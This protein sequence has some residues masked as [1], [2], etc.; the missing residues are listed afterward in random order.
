M[1]KM[2]AVLWS[3]SMYLPFYRGF[4]CS[5]SAAGASGLKNENTGHYVPVF[6]DPANGMWYLYSFIGSIE[7]ANRVATKAEPLLRKLL[8]NQI[9]AHHI[10]VH[11]LVDLPDPEPEEDFDEDIYKTTVHGCSRTRWPSLSRVHMRSFRATWVV[12]YWRTLRFRMVRSLALNNLIMI[13][14]VILHD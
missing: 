12:S 2:V 9:T 3:Q 6:R 4:G 7:D 8:T 1:A 11:D 10:S 13:R 14:T 5:G